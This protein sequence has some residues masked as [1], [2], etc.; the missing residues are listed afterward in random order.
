MEQQ[1]NNNDLIGKMI[2]DY[3]MSPEQRANARATEMVGGG[4][5]AAPGASQQSTAP[6]LAPTT[7]QTTPAPF[8]VQ[9]WYGKGPSG[10]WVTV[11]PGT[12]GGRQLLKDNWRDPS[13]WSAPAE[14]A[15]PSAP[16]TP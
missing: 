8:Q 14:V 7:Q 11:P 9:G 3:T 1:N 6:A 4:Q 2:S 5:G 16:T 15:L 10:Q 13:A 12:P